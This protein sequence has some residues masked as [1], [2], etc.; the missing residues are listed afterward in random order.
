MTFLI[1]LYLPDTLRDSI[2]YSRYIVFVT[3][4]MS[5]SSYPT[6]IPKA[7]SCECVAIDS[8]NG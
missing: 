3:T 7:L 8:H 4:L 1:Y 2:K 5:M 6:D